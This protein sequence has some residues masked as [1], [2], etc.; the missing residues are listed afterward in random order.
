VLILAKAMLA[1]MI[2]FILSIICGVVLIPL[3]KKMHVGQSVSVFLKEKHKGKNGTPTM[4]GFIFI[5]PTLV[6]ILFLLLTNK[7]QFSTNLFII[8]FVFIAYAFLGFIDDYLIIKRKSNFGLSEL[9]K[10]IG[11]LIIA[12]VLFCHK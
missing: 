4:G 10:L 3:F 11:Q 1:M 7:I 5:I 2:G 8:I 12:I 6:T 9:Q